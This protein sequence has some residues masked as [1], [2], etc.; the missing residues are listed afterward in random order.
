MKKLIFSLI[1]LAIFLILVIT[2]I[3]KEGIF[4]AKKEGNMK[5]TSIFNNN[6]N[7]PSIYTCDGDDIAPI[8]E[9]SEVPKNTKELALIVD[10]P[11]APMGTWVHWV[12]YNIPTATGTI[13]AN[14]LPAGT[15]EGITDFKRLGWGGPCP[16]NGEHRYFFKLYA[17]DKSVELEEGA[18]KSQLENAMRNHIIDKVE[19]IGL[20]KR[21]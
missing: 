6:E 20:Y 15:K 12:L 9:I 5:L 14:N 11:D 16:P 8:L 7:I 17:L 13:D 10:D 21:K 4:I 2:N 1:L 3:A 19:L 18:T